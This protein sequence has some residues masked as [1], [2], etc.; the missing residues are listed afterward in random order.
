MI[1]QGTPGSIV[2]ISSINGFR[3]QPNMPAYTVSKH[4]II[5]FTKHA[6]MEGGAHNIRV[7]AIAP[8]ATLVSD[9]FHSKRLTSVH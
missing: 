4:A 5:G 7:N 3:P 8:G 1:K 9:S 2:N 6:A